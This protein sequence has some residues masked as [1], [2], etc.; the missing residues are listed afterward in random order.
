MTPWRYLSAVEK[1]EAQVKQRRQQTRETGGLNKRNTKY[2]QIIGTNQA[3]AS[4]VA[5][6]KSAFAKAGVP[7]TE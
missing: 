3:F 5:V 7:N 6:S 4:L 2:G 1:T